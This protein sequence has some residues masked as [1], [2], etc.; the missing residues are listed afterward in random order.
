MKSG[1]KEERK[2]PSVVEIVAFRVN[3]VKL[4]LSRPTASHFGF[5]PELKDHTYI[6]TA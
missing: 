3:G 1:K 5:F 2:I 6:F 4:I